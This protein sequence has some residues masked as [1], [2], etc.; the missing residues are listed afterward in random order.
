MKNTLL[1]TWPLMQLPT[2]RR[3]AQTLSGNKLS[4]DI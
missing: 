4:I 3:T 1:H 2:T